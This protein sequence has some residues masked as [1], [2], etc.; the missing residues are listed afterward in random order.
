MAEVVHELTRSHISKLATAGKRVDG[1]DLEEVRPLT[2]ERGFAANAEGS[3]RVHLGNTDVLVG[4]KL[5]LGTPYPDT[6]DSGVLI[7]NAEL[8][9]LA[10]PTFEAGPPRQEAIELARVVDRGI[11]ET[12]TIDFK[13]LCIEPGEKV[14]LLFVDLHVLDYD[15]NLFD[16]CSY[17]ALAALMDTKVPVKAKL[18]ED[19]GEDLDLE[20]KHQPISVTTAKIGDVL[21]VDPALD[22]ER[23]AE[24]RLTVTTDEDGAIRAM[25]KGLKGSFTL[26]EVDRI[27]RLSIE[28]GKE[29][30]K[31]IL[32]A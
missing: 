11:R 24:A 32:E 29:I 2:V 22:E 1:R 9:P 14:W 23:I 27:V 20:V 3:A 12:G 21:F 25:Q 17:A 8:V 30:R 16:A 28:R 13:K 4:V 7:T 18:G 26:E 19:A 31:A 6:P 15:G 10:S 5:E